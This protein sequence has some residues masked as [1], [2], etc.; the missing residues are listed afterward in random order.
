MD[1]ARYWGKIHQ[2]L[3]AAGSAGARRG[4]RCVARRQVRGAT[5]GAWRVRCVAR[6]VRGATSGG[7]LEPGNGQTGA[8]RRGRGR[9]TAGHATRRYA[10]RSVE[11]LADDARSVR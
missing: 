1:L 9:L 4:L 6:Q 7:E 5:S 11:D 3:G 2:S 10:R 8:A